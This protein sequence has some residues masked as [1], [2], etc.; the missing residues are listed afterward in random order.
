MNKEHFTKVLETK[1]KSDILTLNDHL[2]SRL[3]LNDYSNSK[4]KKFKNQ[5]YFAALNKYQ[6]FQYF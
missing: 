1:K 5:S 6:K 3:I 2:P 4:S